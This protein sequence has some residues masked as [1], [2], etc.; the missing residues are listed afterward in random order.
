MSAFW[1][2]IFGQGGTAA[3][4]RMGNDLRFDNVCLIFTETLE[5]KTHFMVGNV[6]RHTHT[7]RQKQLLSPR[8]HSAPLCLWGLVL[9]SALRPIKCS[10][11]TISLGFQ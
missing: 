4:P 10:I 5:Q 8:L 9:A 11:E 1:I 6:K 3:L 2:G 7:P